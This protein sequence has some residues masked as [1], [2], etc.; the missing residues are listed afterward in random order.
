MTQIEFNHAAKEMLAELKHG[1]EA[2]VRKR[3]REEMGLIYVREYTVKAHVYKRRR[4]YRK[5]RSV[6]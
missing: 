5:L 4:K 2:D 3:W 6:A 1:V